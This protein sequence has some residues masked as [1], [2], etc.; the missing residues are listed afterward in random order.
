MI[1]CSLNAGQYISNYDVSDQIKLWSIELLQILMFQ[2]APQVFNKHHC[3]EDINSWICWSGHNTHC[4]GI[5]HWFYRH[6]HTWLRLL[7]KQK[8]YMSFMGWEWISCVVRHELCSLLGGICGCWCKWKEIFL[9]I[10]V[11]YSTGQKGRRF[12]FEISGRAAQTGSHVPLVTSTRKG[13]WQ[14]DGGMFWM[15]YYQCERWG[16]KKFM[17]T[18][19]CLDH[20]QVHHTPHHLCGCCLLATQM[21]HQAPMLD[22][23]R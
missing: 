7:W 17:Y 16:F 1:K 4:F 14:V 13:G 20:H 11:Q 19:A 21:L 18:L 10:A 23:W 15:W 8:L 3:L 9:T 6:A 12:N 5:Y 2:I 22:Q